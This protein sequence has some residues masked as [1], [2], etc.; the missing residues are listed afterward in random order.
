V[1]HCS[2]L[3]RDT[4]YP[5]LR[6]PFL[7]SLFSGKRWG[8][9]LQSQYNAPAQYTTWQHMRRNQFSSNGR[10]D[11]YGY[12]GRGWP[13]GSLQPLCSHEHIVWVLGRL[14]CPFMWT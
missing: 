2:I 6:I 4:N 10:M 12:F 11:K 3:D 13:V 9:I 8:I 5:D 1:V 14:C 7:S